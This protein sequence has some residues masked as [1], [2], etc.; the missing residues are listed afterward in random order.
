MGNE[1][2]IDITD[3]RQTDT[4]IDHLIDEYVQY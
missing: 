3:F 1:L 4:D 2:S